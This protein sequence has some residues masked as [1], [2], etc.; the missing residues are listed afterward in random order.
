[1]VSCIGEKGKG[2]GKTNIKLKQQ[3]KRIKESELN[4][5][6]IHNKTKFIFEQMF[7]DE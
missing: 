1:M 2:T 5:N 7:E 6:H 4:K 3:Y